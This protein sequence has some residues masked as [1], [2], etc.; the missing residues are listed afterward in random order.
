[1]NVINKKKEIIA[2]NG[3]ASAQSSNER[4]IQRFREAMEDE[5]E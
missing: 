2:L 1:M 5:Y 4:L 3:S